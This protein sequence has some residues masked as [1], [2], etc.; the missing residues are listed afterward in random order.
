VF[1][2]TQSAGTEIKAAASDAPMQVSLEK[3]LLS[4]FIE[5]I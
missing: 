3:L 4:Y 2:N 5:L 1:I